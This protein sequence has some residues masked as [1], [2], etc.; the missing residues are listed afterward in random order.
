MSECVHA[1]PPVLWGSTKQIKVTSVAFFL[2]HESC[3][4]L[5]VSPAWEVGSN[6]G[7]RSATLQK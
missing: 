7:D 4:A 2:I 3:H 5:E 1:G 6:P